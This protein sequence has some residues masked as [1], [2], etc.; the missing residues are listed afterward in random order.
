MLYD[1]IKPG[2]KM[3]KGVYRPLEDAR[4]M[5]RLMEEQ[6]FGKMLDMGCGTGIQGIIAAKMG[7]DVMFADINPNAIEC[8]MENARSNGIR[9]KFVVS[10]VFSNIRGKFNTIAFNAPFLATRPV[11]AGKTNPATDGGIDG[12]EVIDVFLDNYK[13]FVL[14]DHAVF[15]TESYWNDFGADVKR[16]RA[17]IVARKHYPLLGDC[18][19]LRFK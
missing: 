1:E 13:R 18:V 16:L 15:M 12:R 9:G 2:L 3:R 7:C 6:A 14:R 10:D 5:G 8:A 19:V 4:M 17:S 11:E